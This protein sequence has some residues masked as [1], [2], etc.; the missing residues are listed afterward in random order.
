MDLAPR[1]WRES[2]LP[3]EHGVWGYITAAALV[4]LP[5]GSHPAGIG[6]VV[7]MIAAVVGRQA[8][9]ARRR[10]NL[11]GRR[12]LIVLLCAGMVVVSSLGMTWYLA[13]YPDWS[14]WCMGGLI[15]GGGQYLWEW[16]R[17]TP[18]PWLRSALGGIAVACMTG[19]IARAGGAVNH[20]CLV[21]AVVVGSNLIAMVPLVRSQSRGGTAWTRLAI[22]LQVL[23]LALGIAGWLLDF[24]PVAV[25][26]VCLLGFL[27]CL[28]ITRRGAQLSSQAIGLHELAWLPVI[29]I[30]VVFGLRFG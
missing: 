23:I 25:T 4:G 24:I 29:A 9:Q 26:L 22:I 6:I 19:A 27:R 11:G 21:S 5:L 3:A 1:T 17:P 16:W 28:W 2:M 7:F 13:G 30:G 18:R 10:K 12:P 14:L 15:L 20:W 8:I